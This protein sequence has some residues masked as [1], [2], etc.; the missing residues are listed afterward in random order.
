MGEWALSRW[1]PWHLALPWS[2]QSRLL[3][4][5]ALGGRVEVIQ[6]A[7]DIFE[8]GPLLGVVLPAASHDVVELLW[9]VLWSGHPVPV[10]QCPD[11]LRV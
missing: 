10:L 6:H 5:L 11:H 7:L 2:P 8:G 3:L 9:A 1:C 4:V